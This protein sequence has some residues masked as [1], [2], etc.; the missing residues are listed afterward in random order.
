MPTFMH[1][2]Y[3]LYIRKHTQF[4][5]K[6]H[7]LYRFE[8]FQKTSEITANRRKI[9]NRKVINRVV[10][11]FVWIARVPITV[12]CHD[13]LRLGVVSYR[14]RSNASHDKHRDM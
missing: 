9:R 12:K 11:Y 8:H 7:S 4:Q 14:N 6:G 1:L 5:Q 10:F 2:F 13:P 3:L